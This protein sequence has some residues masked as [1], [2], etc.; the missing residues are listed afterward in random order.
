MDSSERE[1][2][3]AEGAKVD[4]PGWYYMSFIGEQGFLGGL[5]LYA[6]NQSLALYDSHRRKLN[7]GGEVAM[8]G[9]MSDEDMRRVPLE[10]RGRLLGREELEQQEVEEEL[11]RRLALE[12]PPGTKVRFHRG[13]MAVAP[14]LTGE[15]VVN[16]IA[17]EESRV[18]VLATVPVDT[19]SAI[20]GHMLR[21]GERIAGQCRPELLE[22]IN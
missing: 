10:N 15:G 4:A 19:P 12:W 8:I 7:P 18:V 11:H 1:Q 20:P 6:Q 17:L 22:R 3:M 16:R 14:E 21:K 9:P 13:A 5:F 2:R